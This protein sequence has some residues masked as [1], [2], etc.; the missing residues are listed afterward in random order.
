MNAARL[1]AP[2]SLAS[3]APCLG[4]VADNRDRTTRLPVPVRSYA[5]GRQGGV[6]G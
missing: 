4:D 1:P 6:F 3:G 2:F 5:N